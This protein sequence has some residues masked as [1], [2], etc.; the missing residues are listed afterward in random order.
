[1]ACVT[2]LNDWEE[3]ENNFTVTSDIAIN[4]KNAEIYRNSFQG[5]GPEEELCEPEQKNQWLAL[6]MQNKSHFDFT[7][8]HIPGCHF[9]V[10]IPGCSKVIS[11]Q[12]I[13]P[14]HVWLSPSL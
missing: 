7:K 9:L 13:L 3:D 8:D 11:N 6:K 2:E 10:W 12:R 1:M 4:I 5:Q 14:L